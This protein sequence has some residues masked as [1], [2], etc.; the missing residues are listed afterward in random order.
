MKRREKEEKMVSLHESQ[1]FNNKT[2][3]NERMQHRQR[4]NF[5]F[6]GTATATVLVESTVN[7]VMCR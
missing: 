3:E 1:T 7:Q 6:K 5:E 4:E 2:Y